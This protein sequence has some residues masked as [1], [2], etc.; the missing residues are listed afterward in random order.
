M[1]LYE[2]IRR[3][4]RVDGL[5]IRALA[6][7]HR[8]HR[9]TVRAA[10]ASAVPAP[11]KVPDRVSP[12]LGPYKDVVRGWLVADEEV[13]A[14]QRHTARRV[15]QRLVAEEGAVV[16]ESTVRAF[17]AALREELADSVRDVTV[18]QVHELGAEAEVDFGDFY[19][20]VDGDA[21]EAGDVL[22]A[23]VG[24]GSCV[25]CGVREPGAGG[26]PG[27]PPGVVRTVRWG[28]GA[29][30]LRQFE[31]GG[32]EGVDGPRPPG[33]SPVHRVVLALWVRPV[34]LPARTGGRPREGWGGGRDRPVSA[35][36]SGPGSGGR[37]AR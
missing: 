18:P 33:D 12:A 25:S 32:G 14:K 6:G 27:R 17:V 28:A 15:W 7:K 36:A 20:Y 31:A 23:A 8:V 22:H 16:A 30:P 5:S 37:F 1:E 13:H 26:V 2:Q 4:A 34:L 10:L 21:G 9:R 11:R 35:P 3:D 29:G 24:V 19:A